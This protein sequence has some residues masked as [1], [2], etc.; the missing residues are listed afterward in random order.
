MPEITTKSRVAVLG[1]LSDLHRHIPAYDLNVLARLV[2]QIQPDLLCAE[3]G[4]DHWEAG[5]LSRMPV[6][7]REALVRVCR[8][9]NIVLVPVAGPCALET[10][11]LSVWDGGR[12]HGL[13]G[14][15]AGLLNW[16]LRLMQRL[17]GTPEAINSG[18]FGVL[19]SWMCGLIAWVCGPE[20]QRT[21]AAANEQIVQ[22]VLAAVRRDPGRRVL[23][24]VDCRRRHLLDRRLRTF[25]EIEVVE[26]DRL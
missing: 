6:E 1:T 18:T 21:W 15:F 8:R 20:A 23:V 22:N 17:A 12:W 3:I 9:S 5:D 26:F 24:T 14:A 2:K 7:Y 19:C 16:Q 25:E 10:D 11:V 13:R 4:R